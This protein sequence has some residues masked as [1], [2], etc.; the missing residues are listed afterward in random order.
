MLGGKPGTRGKL[1]KS[2]CREPFDKILSSLRIR[3]A[4][5]ASRLHAARDRALR[6]V[7]HQRDDDVLRLD[8]RHADQGDQ[9]AAPLPA[10]LPRLA[11][12]EQDG[13][14][15]EVCFVE[16]FVLPTLVHAV[17]TLQWATMGY[18]YRQH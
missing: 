9:G 16:N 8:L 10:Q 6:R 4:W 2:I 15:F 11:R 5:K 7:L 18:S 13:Q 1:I 3:R 17:L 12:R 14:K